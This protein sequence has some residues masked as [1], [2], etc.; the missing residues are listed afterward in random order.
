MDK[1]KNLNKLFIDITGFLLEYI[2]RYYPCDNERLMKEMSDFV[3]EKMKENPDLTLD[4]VKLKFMYEK[5][6]QIENEE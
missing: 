6:K 3:M 2:K 4:L 1:E 5:W